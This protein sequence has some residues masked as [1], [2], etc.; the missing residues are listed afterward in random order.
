MHKNMFF[1]LFYIASLLSLGYGIYINDYR[2]MFLSTF[3]LLLFLIFDFVI[4]KFE[5]KTSFLLKLILFLFLFCSEVLGEAFNFYS[6]YSWWDDMLHFVSGIVVVYFGY[7]IVNRFVKDK[8]NILII[9]LFSFCFSS[10]FGLFWEFIE[11][12]YDMCLNSDMQKDR[13]INDFNTT[14]FSSLSD[15]KRLN[16]IYR[17]DIYTDSGIITIKNGYLDIGLIDT[18]IDLITD[19][20]GSLCG[21]IFIYIKKDF[22]EV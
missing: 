12:E 4:V 5:Y 13:V 18:M 15:I 8:S 22:N 16:R 2:I 20:L 21:S 10:F 11:F 1:Y 9:A 6:K 17:T 19:V 7:L 14:Y 3:V